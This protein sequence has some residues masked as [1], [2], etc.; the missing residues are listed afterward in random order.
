LKKLKSLALSEER[1]IQK[2][3]NITDLLEEGRFV[4][5]PKSESIQMDIDISKLLP[6]AQKWCKR[7][8]LDGQE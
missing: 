8:F 3:M 4:E 5:K 6:E 1:Q 2:G 7:L